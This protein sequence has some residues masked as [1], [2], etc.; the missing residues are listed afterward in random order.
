MEGWLQR[1]LDAES[2]GEGF[3]FIGV[4]FGRFRRRVQWEHVRVRW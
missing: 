2:V 4:T 3:K 1:I